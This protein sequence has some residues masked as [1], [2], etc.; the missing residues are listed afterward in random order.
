MSRRIVLIVI[1]LVSVGVDFSYGVNPALIDIISNAVPPSII[2][3]PTD[4][5]K[6]KP[7]KVVVSGG[8]YC[9]APVFSGGESYIHIRQCWEQDVAN[10]RYDVFQRISYYIHSTWLCITAPENVVRG[11]TNWDYVNLRPCTINDPLQR[12]IVKDG[13]FWSANGRYRLKETTGWYVYISKNSKDKYDHTLDSSMDDWVKTV[14][15]PGNISIL[16]SIAWNLGNDRYFVRLGGSGKNTTPIYYNPE[17]GHLA[18]YNLTSGLL[19]CMYSQVG[20]YNWNWVHWTWCN[21]TLSGKDNPTYWNVSLETEEGGMITDYKDNI[22]RVTRYGPNWGAVYAVK[23]SYLDKDTTNSPTSVFVVDRDL[24]DWTRYT[25]SNLG[26]TELYCPAPGKSLVYKKVK[27]TLPPGFE[28]SDDWI[29]RLYE[30]SMSAAPGS[31]MIRGVCGVCLLHSFQ[32]LAELQEYHSRGPLQEGGYFFDTARN[33]DPF[34]SF[35]QRYPLLNTALIDIPRVYGPVVNNS[36]RRLALISAVTMLPQ[37]SWTLSR[38]ASTMPDILSHITTLIH[39]PPGSAWLALLRRRRPD[40]TAGSHAV[41]MIRTPQGVVV[42]PTA[43]TNLTLDLYRQ[44]LTPSTDPNQIVRNLEARPD[45]TLVRLTTVEL[46]QM[47]HNTFDSMVSNMNC[48]GEGEDR[49]GTGE[50]PTSASVNRCASD[51]CALPF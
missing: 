36:N 15:T 22:L 26:K 27:N 28:L 40:G 17:N 25:A 23:P 46:G 7:I 37:Y 43:T 33:I 18:L 35:G 4:K 47:Y 1:L 45:R 38:D 44:A 9:Y 13:A 6:D 51:R 20:N 2:Q 8:T 10:A 39:S 32:V 16:T 12:W 14:A 19:S 11:E 30:I 24:L 31:G 34:I 49:R 48:S 42:I 41:P 5:P 3:R 21:D 29:R 50:F